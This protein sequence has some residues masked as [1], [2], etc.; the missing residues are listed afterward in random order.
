[1]VS[2]HSDTQA[3]QEYF[4]S[5]LSEPEDYAS[6][7]FSSA[8]KK[9]SNIKE[10]RTPNPSN[11]SLTIKARN[12]PKDQEAFLPETALKKNKSLHELLQEIPFEE[13][14][15]SKN[16]VTHLPKLE[17]K[18]EPKVEESK[19]VELAEESKI[20]QQVESQVKEESAPQ[21][22]RNTAVNT[23][24][25]LQ[26]TEQIHSSDDAA[27]QAELV[28]E[29]Q[30]PDSEWQNIE[31][32]EEFQVLFFVVAGVTFGVPLKE[33]GGIH[34]AQSVT[35]LFGKPA[36]YSGLFY[37]N[38]SAVNVVDTITWIMPEKSYQAEY[39][40]YIMLDDSSWGLSAESLIGTELLDRS[41]IKWRTQAGKRPWLAGMIKEKMCALL[42][43]RELIIL[44]EQGLDISNG[45][46]G[47]DLKN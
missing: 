43:V 11:L 1:M 37:D 4:E 22:E 13:P 7:S 21:A 33:L 15:S 12:K 18:L 39:K 28:E 3:I 44:L 9:E 24:E 40:Y 23:Q 2:R 16:L 46:E 17:P 20:E 29:T 35:P 38:D 34:K 10:N 26:E 47:I 30:E 8:S 45:V 36:W 27:I 32:D 6:D 41:S 31:T 25:Q 42:H 5:L 19:P 14:D